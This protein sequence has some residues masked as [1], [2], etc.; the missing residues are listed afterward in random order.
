MDFNVEAHLALS[1][2]Y[3]A[4]ARGPIQSERGRVD[5]A[6]DSGYHALLAVLTRDER[7]REDPPSVNAVQLACTRLGVDVETGVRL[8]QQ[9]YSADE[10]DGLAAVMV[11]AEQVRA[12]AKQFVEINRA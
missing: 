6:F 10:R 12:R 11:W 4:D 9:R 2:A 1:D 7:P 3:I 8:A 5:C